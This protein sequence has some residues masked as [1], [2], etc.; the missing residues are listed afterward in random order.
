[1]SERLL[2]EEHMEQWEQRDQ[3]DQAAAQ[4]RDD[5]EPLMSGDYGAMAAIAQAEPSY[6][7]TGVALIDSLLATAERITNGKAGL[8]QRVVS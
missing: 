3:T 6:A 7:L 1:M 5:L 4:Q 2:Q 8:L